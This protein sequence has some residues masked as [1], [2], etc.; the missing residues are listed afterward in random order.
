MEHRMVLAQEDFFADVYLINK[1]F[2]LQTIT[3]F[4]HFKKEF[5]KFVRN[6]LFHILQNDHMPNQLIDIIDIIHYKKNFVAVKVETDARHGYNI[7]PPLFFMCMRDMIR[8]W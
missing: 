6:I 7:F 3:A 8:K 4:L 1:E 5:D 2:T